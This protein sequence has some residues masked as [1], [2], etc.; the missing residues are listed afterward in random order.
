MAR[1]LPPGLLVDSVRH[2]D[3]RSATGSLARRA[4]AK[5]RTADVTIPHGPAAGL[6]FNAGGSAP[7]FSLGTTEPEVQTALTELLKPGDVFYDVG[8]NVG[9]YTLLASRLVGP[10]GHVYA[11]EPVPENIRAIEHNLELSQAANVSILPYAVTDTPGIVALTLSAEPFW[12]RLSTL[13]PPPHP[14]GTIDVTGVSIDELMAKELIMPPDVIKLDVE[15][16]EKEVLVGMRETMRAC[17]PRV[18]CELHDTWTEVSSLLAE[19]NYHVS[20]LWRQVRGQKQRSRH[21]VAVPE[22]GGGPTVRSGNPR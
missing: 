19:A 18:V 7:S 22:P 5:L 20:F 14:A 13:P 16:A 6:R 2:G 3:G 17:R 8:A 9:F 1:W 10:S 4:L 11:L 21:I 15:G 12:T